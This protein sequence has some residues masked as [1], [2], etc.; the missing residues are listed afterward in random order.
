MD[1]DIAVLNGQ[2]S[3]KWATFNGVEIA[4]LFATRIADVLFLCKSA[5]PELS[6]G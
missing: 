4:F 1:Q 2:S 3:D 5:V 6:E